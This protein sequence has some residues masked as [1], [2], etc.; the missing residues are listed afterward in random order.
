MNLKNIANEINN[1]IEEKRKK[2]KL[3]FIEDGHIYYMEDQDG[4]VRSDFPS[5]SHVLEQFF[6]PFNADE[7][8]L[9][10]CN[11]DVNEKIKL[12]EKWEYAGTYASNKG[13]RVHY[14]LEK[15]AISKALRNKDIRMPIFECDAQQIV[16]SNNMILAGKQFIDLMFSRGCELIDTEMVLGSKELK[17]VGQA[18]NFWLSYNKNKTDFGIIITDHKT[19]K[20]KNMEPQRYN[21]FLHEPFSDW[22]SYALTHYYI[23]LSLY[24]RLFKDMLNGTKY[25]NIQILGGILNSVRD[26]ATF[27]EY[28]VP[29]VFIDKINNM[30][31]SYY[32]SK[33]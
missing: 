33:K 19:N 31:L 13:S 27:V 26:D 10:M 8:A 6:T 9:Q 23:Q 3:E 32:V 24:L 25:E 28:R 1:I 22:I 5:V 30:D 11:G 21:D 17:Y 15:Y 4:V 7:K 20:V 16:D 14:E 29:R 2:I 18:D 12:I